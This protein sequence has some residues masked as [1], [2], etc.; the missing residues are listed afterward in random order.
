M[1]FTTQNYGF[2]T[3]TSF[4]FVLAQ[5]RELSRKIYRICFASS[6]ILHGCSVR[7]FNCVSLKY[8]FQCPYPVPSRVFFPT[9]VVPYRCTPLPHCRTAARVRVPPGRTHCRTPLP[10]P[11]PFRRTVPY[12]A[13]P[14]CRT[15]LPYTVAQSG[16]RARGPGMR[17][18][19][20]TGYGT[21]RRRQGITTEGSENS[22]EIVE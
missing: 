2:M 14:H 21:V 17:S 8:M 7:K 6:R 20:I 19:H 11:L 16:S 4:S 1:V 12:R 10:Y 15:P 13:V 5:L 3:C 9:A 22:D 18:R